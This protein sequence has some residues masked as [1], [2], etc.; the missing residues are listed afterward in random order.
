MTTGPL[1][2]LPA[3]AAAARK[4]ADDLLSSIEDALTDNP[5]A[6]VQ[7]LWDI[8]EM[9]RAASSPPEHWLGEDPAEGA[10]RR[11]HEVLIGA[12]NITST[13]LDAIAAG[14]APEHAA[15]W[16]AEQDY[17]DTRPRAGAHSGVLDLT[18]PD[19][20]DTGRTLF[21]EADVW[22]DASQ[23]PGQ[24]LRLGVTAGK[25][26]SPEPRPYTAS[27]VLRAGHAMSELAAVLGEL[28]LEPAADGFPLCG[29]PGD[30]VM[31]A[32]CGQAAGSDVARRVEN[33]YGDYEDVCS[34]SCARTV[35]V[36][37]DDE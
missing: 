1:D 12:T 17:R 25:G 28:V 14:M 30:R 9:L 23:S 3:D 2:D 15:D 18:P 19:H 33:P 36:A 29:L 37:R 11:W 32:A 16:L 27:T 6:G 13:A 7:L 35:H 5:P 4:A 22:G 20:P 34:V 8:A 21:V 31:C 26:P 10:R 24:Q